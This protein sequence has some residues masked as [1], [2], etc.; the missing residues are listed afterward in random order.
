MAFDEALAQRVRSALASLHGV[1]EKKMF[2]GIA[3]MRGGAMLVGVNKDDLIIRCA[4]EDTDALLRK[5]GV[6]IFDLSGGRP[7]KG[8]LLVGST[9]TRAERGLQAWITFA[10]AGSGA[11]EKGAKKVST[12]RAPKG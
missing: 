5:P 9:A 7:M 12:V 1:T 6:R 11:T 2:G 8:W 3:F 10:M 4:G